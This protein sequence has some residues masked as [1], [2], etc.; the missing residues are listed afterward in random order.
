M[1]CTRVV[2]DKSPACP[3]KERQGA[4]LLIL[5][6]FEVKE[7]QRNNSTR[8]HANNLIAVEYLQESGGSG[9]WV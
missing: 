1:R 6:P 4:L 8:V 7:S 9:K 3:E 2:T 5:Q